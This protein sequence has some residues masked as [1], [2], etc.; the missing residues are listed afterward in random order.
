MG[1][2][3]HLALKKVKTKFSGVIWADQI[4]LKKHWICWIFAPY[5]S[6]EPGNASK[7]MSF[8]VR[9]FLDI[10]IFILRTFN[11]FEDVL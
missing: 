11:L 9:T 4:Y 5:G 1:H 3:V 10:E 6:Y 8:D 2:A 7:I